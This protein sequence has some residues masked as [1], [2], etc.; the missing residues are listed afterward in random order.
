MKTKK[1]DMEKPPISVSPMNA[2]SRNSRQKPRASTAGRAGVRFSAA[3]VSGSTK[4]VSAR[5]RTP[6]SASTAKISRQLPTAI[7]PLPASGASI[8]ETRDHQHH[9][10]HQ[11]RRLRP[12]CAGRG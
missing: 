9:H 8:G 10:R 6:A 4:A 1:L 3:S 11:P 2:G 7:S 5:L 12:R